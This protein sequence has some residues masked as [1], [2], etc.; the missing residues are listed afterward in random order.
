MSGA[1]RAS[2]LPRPIL[3]PLSWAYGLAVDWRNRRFDRGAGVRRIGCPVVSIGNLTAGG[4]GKTPMVAEVVQRLA[5]LGAS[6]IVALRGYRADRDG[7]SD[8]A[9]LHRQALP[10]VPVVVGP[11]RHSSLLASGRSLA[12]PSVVVLDDGFQHRQL[13]RDLDI[14][15]VDATRDAL[16][17]P[18]LPAGWL[19]EPASALK[20]AD[21]VVVTRADRID[22]AVADR[23]E[24]LHGRP[25][26]A[27]TRHAWDGFDRFVGP[28]NRRT[29]ERETNE[30]IR[31]KAIVTLLGV[32]N[33][34]PIRAT[35]ASLGGV[36]RLAL[37][38]SDH[39]RYGDREAIEIARLVEKSG[40][41]CLL[42]TAKD[43][44]K[45][46]RVW[47]SDLPVAVPR[48]RIEWIAGEETV[49]ALLAKTVERPPR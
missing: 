41:D 30:W 24:Q 4:T 17:D 3:L 22:A 28:T 10:G 16:G 11:D 25:P 1:D 15:L 12:A 34:G 31:G 48:L 42:T 32:G 33:P 2:R 47:R 21:A 26:I 8:E 45:L 19:R 36:E 18:L 49:E 23:I 46:G 37:P 5:R 20:R 38:A 40:A 9:E 39:Q 7:F 6:P 13:A 27:W 44:V 14:V 43:W 29:G 35:L